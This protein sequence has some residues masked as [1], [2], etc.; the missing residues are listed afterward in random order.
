MASVDLNADLGEGDACDDALLEIVSSCNVACGGHAGDSDSMAATVRAAMANGVSVGAHPGYP[1]REGFGRVSGYLSGDAL[2]EA[3]TDQVTAFAD[4]AAQLGAKLAHVKPHGALYNDAI[5]DAELADVIARVV[6]EL[7][8]EPAF[9]GMANTQL[10]LAAER[11]GLE[12]IAEAFVDRAYEADGTLVSRSEPGAV[13]GEL[14]VIT[15]QALGLAERGIVTARNGEIIEVRADTLCIHGDTPGAA[16]A[17]RAV[18][19]V[20]ESHGVEIRAHEKSR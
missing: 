7:H 9:V 18:R 5:A 10:Q 15:S 6:S 14:F 4:I 19:D 13:H 12:F 8:G 11:H 2:Y 17:A 20:L 3:L 16:E 1:D